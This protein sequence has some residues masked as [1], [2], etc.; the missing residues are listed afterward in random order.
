MDNATDGFDVY[1][2]ESGN[3]IRNL[4]TGSPTKR[5][6]KQVAFGEDSKVIVGGSD[7]GV[8]YVFDRKTGV[9]LDHL[10]HAKGGMVQAVAVSQK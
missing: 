7:H 4:P 2:L 5:F 8:V 10:H 9:L 3:F 1:H 6:P